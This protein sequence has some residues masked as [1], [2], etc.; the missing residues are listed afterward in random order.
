MVEGFY[1]DS[2]TSPRLSISYLGK[3]EHLV[4]QCAADDTVA[5]KVF[6]M[7]I[8]D[9]IERKRI[10]ERISGCTDNQ[11]KLQWATLIHPF[12]NVSRSAFISKGTTIFAG[13][14]IGPNTKIGI[15]SIINVHA[16]LGHDSTVGDYV[17]IAPGEHLRGAVTIRSLTLID[18]GSQIIPHNHIVQKRIMNTGTSVLTN[19]PQITKFDGILKTKQS[20]D[21]NFN[22]DRLYWLP[23]K[24]INFSRIEYLLT[25]SVYHNHFANF[26]PCVRQLEVVLRN[27]F[28]IDPS[29]AIILTNNGSAALHAIIGGLEI[30]HKKKLKFATQAFTFPT[31]VQ[32]TLVGST[33]VDVDD[34]GGLDLNQIQISTVDGIIVT[35]TFGHVLDLKKYTEWAKK[36]SK[37]LIFDNAATSYTF[38]E[39]KCVLVI[40]SYEI[41]VLIR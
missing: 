13:A 5:R 16:S 12:S 17:H 32:G 11:L 30:F 37:Y 21:T 9:N 29:K 14:V 18:G 25:E 33:I 31:S 22:D 34:D 2:L 35:N 41:H 8:E 19:A 4:Q 40:F 26:G 27:I 36:F 24:P 20:T 6:A 3:I 28:E 1:D 7:C 38:Y 15:H 10:V 39:G 23:K